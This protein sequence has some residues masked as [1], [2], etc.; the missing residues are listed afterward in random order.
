[1]LEDA[2]EEGRAEG[3]KE[4]QALAAENADLKAKLARA[5]AAG[6]VSDAKTDY[7]P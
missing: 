5:E 4:R 6:F 2:K 3:E 7:K 1:M